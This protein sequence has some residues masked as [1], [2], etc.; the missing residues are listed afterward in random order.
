M[1]NLENF[2]SREDPKVKSIK[3]LKAD[4]DQEF[5]DQFG[6]LAQVLSSD[7]YQARKQTWIKERIDEVLELEDL[8]QKT[9]NLIAEEKEA[10]IDSVTGLERREWLFK[11][12]NLKVKELLEVDDDLSE[13]GWLTKLEEQSVSNLDSDQ[14]PTVMIADVSYL[15]LINKYGH[16]KGD[17]L[18]AR[19][20][21]SIRNLRINGF[22]HGGDE[23]SAF[24]ETKQEA[25]EK[26]S[27]LEEYFRK[28]Q[29]KE[30]KQDSGLDPKLDVGIATYQEA[31]EVIQAL[32][33]S[34]EARSFMTK[35]KHPLKVFN[36]VWADLADKRS[37]QKKGRDRIKILMT[38]YEENPANYKRLLHYL[39]KGAYEISDDKIKEL[40]ALR[41]K[42]GE[43]VLDK[44]IYEF[45]KQTELE[46]LQALSSASLESE[47]GNFSSDITN[48][49]KFEQLKTQA[50]FDL[51]Y[52]K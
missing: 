8:N 35:N 39:N 17:Q 51:I 43:E 3:L 36:T 49:A 16:E 33:V 37:A 21:D 20:G 10:R 41:N 1:T 30:L 29:I 34:P 23:L 11:A 32:L 22:R 48:Q 5:E 12:M 42:S 13:E 25:L 38:K 44:G 24:F 19:A 28:Q 4:L 40:I 45:I 31:L 46:N 2:P 26:S 7:K 50:I 6:D 9:E 14:A 15:N 27:K 47:P 52:A 18:L